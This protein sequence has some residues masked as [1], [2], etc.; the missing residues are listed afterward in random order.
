M[1]TIVAVV[2]Y[3]PEQGK[4]GHRA[5][6]WRLRRNLMPELMSGGS[7]LSI[8]C[9]SIRGRKAGIQ[10][11]A[12]SERTSPAGGPLHEEIDVRSHGYRW[13]RGRPCS[14]PYLETDARA[15]ALSA[16]GTPLRLEFIGR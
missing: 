16:C 8:G 9:T 6:P 13:G 10:I 3:G 14:P 2:E 7:V 12:S 11:A 5:Y 15:S 1:C 4:R